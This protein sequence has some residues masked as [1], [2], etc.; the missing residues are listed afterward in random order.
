MFQLGEI[1]YRTE[2]RVRKLATGSQRQ[3]SQIWSRSKPPKRTCV[4]NVI[5]TFDIECQNIVQRTDLLVCIYYYSRLMVDPVVVVEFV[6]VKLVTTS[7]M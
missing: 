6:F 5:E 1:K 3:K 7:G 2:L 4:S